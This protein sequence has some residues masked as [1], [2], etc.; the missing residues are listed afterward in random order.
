MGIYLFQAVQRQRLIGKQVWG[1]ALFVLCLGMDIVNT[2]GDLVLHLLPNGN[3]DF[4][5]NLTT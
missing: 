4:A 1:I 5:G 2:L 3:P